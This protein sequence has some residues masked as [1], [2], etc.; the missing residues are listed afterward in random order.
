MHRGARCQNDTVLHLD[1]TVGEGSYLQL[2]PAS[3]EQK[4]LILHRQRRKVR[5]MLCPCYQLEDLLIRGVANVRHCVLRMKEGS[6]L[7]GSALRSSFFIE[8][9]VDL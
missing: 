6:E 1:R 9:Q 4:R 3:L 5:D 2:V 7:V 8:R